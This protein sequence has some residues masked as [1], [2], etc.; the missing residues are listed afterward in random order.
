MLETLEISRDSI[1]TIETE[2][3]NGLNKLT[4]IDLRWRD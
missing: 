2:A 1:S 4:K 3:F